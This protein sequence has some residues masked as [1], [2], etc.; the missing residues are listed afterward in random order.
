VSHPIPRFDA[1]ANHPLLKKDSPKNAASWAP[2]C[3]IFE[4]NGGSQTFFAD[5]EPV[6]ILTQMAPIGATTKAEKGEK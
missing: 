2:K 4:T 5:L 6:K 3:G 1:S